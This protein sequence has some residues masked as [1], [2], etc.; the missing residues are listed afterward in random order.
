MCYPT[1]KCHSMP[2]SAEVEEEAA[3]ASCSAPTP[4]AKE[5][6]LHPYFLPL[7]DLQQADFFVADA[8][9]AHVAPLHLTLLN[10]GW[11]AGMAAVCTGLLTGAQPAGA[12]SGRRRRRQLQHA[13]V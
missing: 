3:P 1:R 12:A 2:R 7:H 5:V 11:V 10:P 13:R 9:T 6:S 8:E 4:N